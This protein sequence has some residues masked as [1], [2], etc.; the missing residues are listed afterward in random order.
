M[1]KRIDTFWRYRNL[2]FELV[3]KGI[4][5]KYRRS[6]LGIIWSLLEPVMTTIVLTIVFGTL[7]GNKD[8]TFPLYILSGRL[9]FLFC[10]GHESVTEIDPTKFGHDKES[11]CAEVSVSVIIRTL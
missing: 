7:Y 10:T 3:K 8:H 9:L 11:V 4:K 6:Y 5:L 2:L 1:K